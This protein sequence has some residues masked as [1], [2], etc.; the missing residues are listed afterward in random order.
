MTSSTP[1]RLST[2]RSLARLIPFAR[3]VLPRLGLGA[4]S[5]GAA[6]SIDDAPAVP[7]TLGVGESLDVVYRW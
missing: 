2:A 6:V 4:A 1:P 3:P 7:R 5:G